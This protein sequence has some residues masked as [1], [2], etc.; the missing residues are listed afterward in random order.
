MA[1]ARLIHERLSTTVA[2]K[3]ISKP[4]AKDLSVAMANCPNLHTLNLSGQW[5]ASCLSAV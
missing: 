3:K 4:E 2:G 5:V 1:K